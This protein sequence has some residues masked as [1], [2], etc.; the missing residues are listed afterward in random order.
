MLDGVDGVPSGE[1]VEMAPVERLMLDETSWV[2]VARHW[3]PPDEADRLF[4]ALRDGVAWQTGRLFRYD[5]V[6]EERRLGSF[7]RPGRPLPDPALAGIHKTLQRT[8]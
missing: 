7:W 3:I 6:V 1:T 5:H 8:Y 2:D 4:A